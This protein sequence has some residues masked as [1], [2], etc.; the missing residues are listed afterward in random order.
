MKEETT[1]G[2]L[3]NA[4]RSFDQHVARVSWRAWA[5]LLGLGIVIGVVIVWSV[6]GDIPTRVAGSCIIMNPRGV[7]DVTADMEGRVTSMLVQPGDVIA[8]GQEL[9]VVA[10]PEL[11]DRIQ[12]ARNRLADLEASARLTHGELQR[13]GRLS[14][15]SLAE[16]RSALSLRAE[17]DRKRIRLL[18]QQMEL[19]QRLRSEGLIT[20]RAAAQTPLDLEEARAVLA[21]TERQLAAVDKRAADFARSSGGSLARI[22]QQK[23]EAQRELAALEAQG[24]SVTRLRSAV[25]GRVVEVK[26]ALNGAVKRD[27][28]VLS[29]EA[30]DGGDQLEAVMF[31][32]AAD[33]KKISAQDKVE[34]LPTHA[35]REEHGV[36]RAQVLS[37][38]A[39]PATPQGLL[40]TITNP[41]LMREL[42]HGTASYEV[43]IG[44]ERNAAA[45]AAA[46]NPYLWSA[47]AGSGVP[48]T[49]GA[50]CRGEILVHHERP[51]SLVLP[52]F[53]STVSGN[54]T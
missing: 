4:L 49:S 8:A 10:T 44:L 18:E 28:P 13:S 19:D 53:R 7:S 25:A 30:L 31:V 45:G 34:L 41:E 20:K 33:G 46:R 35:R 14:S 47:V 3:P 48:V 27:T 23:A 26:T 43:R 32:S 29:V 42:A 9:A 52:I 11:F 6:F 12:Q 24:Q 2:R 17:A 36:L 51:I 5:N 1:T 54:K 37:T 16:Q 38:S 40:N 15:E 22:D 21:D 50:L 39:Y